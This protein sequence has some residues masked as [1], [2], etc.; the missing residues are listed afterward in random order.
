MHYIELIVSGIKEYCNINLFYYH[1]NQQ[2]FLY[3]YYNLKLLELGLSICVSK[4]ICLV[5]MPFFTSVIYLI[6]A[7]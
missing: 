6:L 4:R 5:F 7:Y 3:L 2:G 1:I